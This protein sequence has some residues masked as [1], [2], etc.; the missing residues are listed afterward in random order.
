MAAL[1][2][3]AT[4]LRAGELCALEV[5]HFD[6]SSVKVEQ[7][8][9]NG[10]VL[11]PKTMNAFRVVDLHPDVASLLKTYIGNR[12]SGF[13][14][15]TDTGTPM[16]QS[17][18]LR[19]ELHPLLDSLKIPRCGFHAFRRFRNTH[20]RNLHCPDGLLKFWMGHAGRDMSDRYDRVRDDL[21]FRKDVALSMGVGFEL[22]RTLT[23]NPVL[24][25]NGR[26]AEAAVEEAVLANTQ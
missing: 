26:Q 6:G 3:A 14:F 24:G 13:I 1:L 18:T 16:G 23:S 5:R 11:K 19:R 25:A 9:W 12:S 15:E 8:V 7:G 10:K 17:N 20:L 21:Q 4:G 2:F 22:P